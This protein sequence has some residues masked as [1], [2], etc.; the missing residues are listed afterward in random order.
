MTRALLCC[1]LS[2]VLE[3]AES[4][5]FPHRKTGVTLLPFLIG[6]WQ[7]LI[8]GAPYYFDRKEEKGGAVY[9][10]M[11][12]GGT[13]PSTPNRTLTGPSGS[14]FGLSVAHIGDVDK[15]DFQ[16]KPFSFQAELMF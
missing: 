3:L 6:R 9:V 13:F 4:L 5:H 1:V 7:D 11:N 2:P 15:D 8:V 12:L 16:G 14:S 10:Y